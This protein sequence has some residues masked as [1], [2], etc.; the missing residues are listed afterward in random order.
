MAL[1]YRSFIKSLF[2]GKT[3]ILPRLRMNRQPSDSVDA[4]TAQD[5]AEGRSGRDPVG[6]C[7]PLPTVYGCEGG[8][9]KI[10]RA[11]GGQA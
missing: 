7:H 11:G 5:D 3:R 10:T 6:A 8:G 1:R 2:S 4:E 9:R